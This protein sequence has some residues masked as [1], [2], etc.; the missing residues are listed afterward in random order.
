MSFITLTNSDTTTDTFTVTWDF[1]S[2]M[3]MFNSE[4]VETH[5]FRERGLSKEERLAVLDEMIAVVE[6]RSETQ[7]W[8]K[9]HALLEIPMEDRSVTG[10]CLSG[11]WFRFSENLGQYPRMASVDPVLVAIGKAI[12]EQ[13]PHRAQG[14]A[15]GPPEGAVIPFN[16]HPNT[17]AADVVRVLEKARVAID[18]AA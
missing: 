4:A 11:M 3:P 6:G 14:G 12:Q 15:F 2:V 1:T 16:D 18:E 10:M 5:D 7:R 17:T 9:G 13:F 8:I